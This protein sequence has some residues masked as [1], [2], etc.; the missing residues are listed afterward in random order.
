[1][2]S[3]NTT[4]LKTVTA[5]LIT[6][7]LCF[8]G[9]ALYDRFAGGPEARQASVQASEVLDGFAEAQQRSECVTTYAVADSTSQANLLIAFGHLIE[10]SARDNVGITTEEIEDLHLATVQRTRY[11]ALRTRTNEFCDPSQD[12]GI[13]PLPDEDQPEILT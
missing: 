7:I 12:G 1:M 3:D 8:A 4:L 9:A 10:S 2:T 13:R 6:G 11:L 5:V